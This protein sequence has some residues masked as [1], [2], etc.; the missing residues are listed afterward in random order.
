MENL[1]LP[2]NGEGCDRLELGEKGAVRTQQSSAAGELS[3]RP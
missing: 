1:K 3:C 2:L